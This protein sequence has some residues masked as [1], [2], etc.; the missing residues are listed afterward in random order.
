MQKS[1]PVGGIG[2][3]KRERSRICE[4]PPGSVLLPHLGLADAIPSYQILSHAIAA[5]LLRIGWPEWEAGE[6]CFA[7]AKTA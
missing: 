4:V 3:P 7:L 1:L 6:L 2:L 5:K